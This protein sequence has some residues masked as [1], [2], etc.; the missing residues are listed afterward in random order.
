MVR[1]S[2]EGRKEGRGYVERISIVGGKGSRDSQE[3]FAGEMCK[4]GREEK[5]KRRKKRKEVEKRKRRKKRKKKRKRN[6]KEV[7]KKQK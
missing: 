3:G 2:P 4:E 5:G 6:K 7:E 1:A